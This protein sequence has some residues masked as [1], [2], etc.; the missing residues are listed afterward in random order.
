MTTKFSNIAGVVFGFRRHKYLAQTLQA[1]EKCQEAD[2]VTWYAFLDGAVN[3]IS[4]NRYAKDK[5]IEKSYRLLC[6][7]SL[8]FDITRSKHNECISL[9]KDKAHK[10]YDKHDCIYFFEDDLIVSPYYLRLL[11]LALSQYPTYS[12]LFNTSKKS[13]ADLSHLSDC[14]IARIWGY[15][16][17]RELYRK[18]EPEW[19]TFV[20]FISNYDYL[21]RS[22]TPGF[23]RDVRRA[24]IIAP[25]HDIAITRLS[26]K[27]GGGKLWPKRSRGIYIGRSGAITFRTDRMWNKRGMKEQPKKIIFERDRKIKRFSI[28]K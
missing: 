11:R 22:T 17:T 15:G 28:V 24:N 21:L 25:S 16:M 9:Q 13:G 4:G 3:P 7:S 26:R 18:I 1:L 27:H 19:E 5:N 12:I 6:E 14:S 23:Y 20:N 8:N 10:L 2:G